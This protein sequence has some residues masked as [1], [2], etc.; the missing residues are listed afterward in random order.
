[1]FS[2]KLRNKIRVYEVSNT[3]DAAGGATT[4]ETLKYTGWASIEPMKADESVLQDRE[5][6]IQHY[7]IRTRYVM[8]IKSTYRIEDVFNSVNYNIISVQNLKNINK[9]YVLIGEVVS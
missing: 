1:M 5:N 7:K 6:Y 8:D 4:S 9:E 3:Q 2:G